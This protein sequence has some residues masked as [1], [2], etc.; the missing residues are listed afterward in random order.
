MGKPRRPNEW[1]PT[2]NGI[3]TLESDDTDLMLECVVDTCDYFHSFP[4]TL[5]LAREEA[6]RHSAKT[7]HQVRVVVTHQYLY[8][9]ER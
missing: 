4:D 3:V 9:P 7:G 5:K 1:A 2:K 8:G 6:H